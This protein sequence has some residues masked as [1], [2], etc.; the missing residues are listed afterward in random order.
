MWGIM[1]SKYRLHINSIGT[2]TKDCEP[3][4]R[5]IPQNG[6]IELVRLPR[7]PRGNMDAIHEGTPTTMEKDRCI[8][9]SFHSE[10]PLRAKGNVISFSDVRNSCGSKDTAFV[11][12]V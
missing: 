5:E 12:Y 7:E 3:G 10:F 8:S 11:G 1:H 9:V 2:S 6:V 4:E